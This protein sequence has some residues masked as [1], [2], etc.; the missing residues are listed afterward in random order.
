M[1][2]YLTSEPDNIAT[3][4]TWLRLGFTNPLADLTVNGVHVTR[5]F[6]A[7]GKDRAV[8]E[9]PCASPGDASPPT[10]VFTPDFAARP[11][12]HGRYRVC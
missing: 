3:H 7:A 11:A 9:L 2:L 6:K 12:D 5:D 4:A 1:R 8:Y 10:D